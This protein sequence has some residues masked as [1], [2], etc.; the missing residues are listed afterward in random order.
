[1][2]LKAKRECLVGLCRLIGTRIRPC[3]LRRSF[4]TTIDH[5]AVSFR[6]FGFLCDTH[7]R[8]STTPPPEDPRA[9]R[10]PTRPQEP[11]P[12]DCCQNQCVECVWTVYQREMT[13]YRRLTQPSDVVTEDPFAA[14]EQR[15]RTKDDEPDNPP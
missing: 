15:L 12:E 7:N 11:G 1:M 9:A 8:F 6:F 5:C 13:A 2:K 10:T 4:D 3:I 14:L